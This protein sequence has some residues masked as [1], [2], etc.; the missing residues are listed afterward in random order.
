MAIDSSQRH[1][2][3][4]RI[5]QTELVADRSEAAKMDKLFR[6]CPPRGAIPQELPRLP[7]E[8]GDEVGRMDISENQQALMVRHKV[9]IPDAIRFDRK[10]LGHFMALL[11]EQVG[12]TVACSFETGS[13]AKKK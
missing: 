13:E 9:R 7:V 2:R 1:R 8:N 3:F 12:H 6:P 11:S 5:P 4:A 10:R